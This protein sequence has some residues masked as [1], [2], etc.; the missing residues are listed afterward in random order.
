MASDIAPRGY[1][2]LLENLKSRIRSARIQAAL[3]VNRELILL[4]W[5]IGRTILEREQREG[6]G[7]K[8][9]ERL[10]RDLRR[11]FPDMKGL[12]RPNLFYMR[13]FAEA[14][15]DHEFVQQVA[16][17]LPWFHNVVIFTKVKDPAQREWYLRACTEYGWS[18][19]V[20]EAQIE[21]RLHERSG[22]ALSNFSLTLPAAQSELAQQVLKDPY[23]LEFLGVYDVLLER[24]LHRKLLEHL[25]DFMLE[26]GVGFAFVGSQYPL[27]V[28][29]EDYY[30]D[31]LFYHLNLRCFV[32]LELKTTGFKPEHIGKLNFYL[33]AV[34]DLLRH[35][36]DNPTIG[37]LL[38][39]EKNRLVVEYALR[40][41]RKPLGVA[42][43]HLA[44]ALPAELKGSLPSVQELQAELAKLKVTHEELGRVE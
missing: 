6:W 29:G 12:S 37:L 38:C 24:D 22:R 42:E 18:R 36:Q 44:Q 20:L 2:E 35:P 41:V 14:Y 7:S 32:V 8:V 10:A 3:S 19:A 33:S 17:Q 39:K 21:T 31:L 25:R 15:P 23:N 16:G 26:L 34:D 40:D 27:Q 4:Y 11:E 43:Y 1:A 28:G 13:A 30:L 9:V 5:D